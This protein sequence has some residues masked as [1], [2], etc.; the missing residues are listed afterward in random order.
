[1][2]TVTAVPYKRA[3]AHRL[4]AGQWEVLS[5]ESPSP[6]PLVLSGFDYGSIL[7]LRREVIIDAAGLRDDC[8]LAENV[9]LLAAASW[10]S[11]GTVLR[12]GLARVPICDGDDICLVELF[13]DVAGSDIAGALHIDTTILVAV[14]QDSGTPL[15]ARHAGAVLLQERQTIQLDS[16]HSF[17]PVEVVDFS[18]GH[19]ANPEAGWRLSWNVFALEQPFLGSVRLLI[20]A[21][22]PGVV[23]AVSG[24]AP[25]AEAS[26]IRSSIYFDTAKALIF[27]ALASEDFIERDGDYAEGSCGRIIYEMIQML[28]PGDGLG[29]LAAAANQ[30]PDYF[31]TDLQGRLR[32][33]W[34]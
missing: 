29:G 25:N 12:R 3:A 16:S 18:K 15:S 8:G 27:G 19:W 17:F 34:I 13:G 23:H 5:S 21:A 7:R 14:R 1:M 26:A 2:K 33:F 4:T 11:P 32:L 31:S 22:H 24:E 6:L 30:R 20:N 28:F 10:S 9:P